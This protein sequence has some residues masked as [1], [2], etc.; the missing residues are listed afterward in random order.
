MQFIISAIM[1][2]LLLRKHGIIEMG[3]AILVVWGILA[4]IV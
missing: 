2:I 1:C 4:V 3:L